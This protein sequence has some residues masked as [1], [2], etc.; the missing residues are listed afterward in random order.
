MESLAHALRPLNW[1]LSMSGCPI[2]PYKQKFV[3]YLMNLHAVALIIVA[4]KSC[5]FKL[6]IGIRSDVAPIVEI[7]MF[8][9]NLQHV[10][11]SV[12]FIL[13]LWKT[14]GQ[15]GLFLSELSGFLNPENNA[16]I[17]RFT[18]GLLVNQMF[19]Y[20]TARVVYISFYFWEGFT[21]GSQLKMKQLLLIYL[22]LHDWYA[23]TLSLYLTLLKVVHMVE[24]NIITGATMTVLKSSPRVVYAKVLKVIELKE[25]ASRQI[26]FLVCLLFVHVFVAA[27]G[28]ICRIQVV[29]FDNRVPE[30]SRLYSL[31]SFGRFSITFSQI[32]FLVFMVH[33]WSRE[34]QARLASLSNTI[35][36]SRE[37]TVQWY[38]VLDIIKVAQKYKYTAFDF[39]DIDRQLLL[40]F[41]ASFVPLT[42]LFVQLIS[43][44]FQ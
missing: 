34:S 14:K 22:Q 42:V 10:T 5:S 38:P 30:S 29:Y 3:N 37:N 4:I 1:S 25:R 13:V 39:F 35:F 36:L 41:V 20:M 26:S 24:S 16:K 8:I 23:E 32:A 33:K 2:I 11:C 18:I 43:Q 21:H 7:V 31:I 9:W 15:L 6:E 27:V 17:F 12:V 40:S 28:S 44:G 19:F